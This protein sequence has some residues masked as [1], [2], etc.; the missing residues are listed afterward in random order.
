M[1]DLVTVT[2]YGHS[3]TP[4]LHRCPQESFVERI[5]SRKGPSGNLT[6]IAGR[7]TVW[8][9]LEDI[10]TDQCTQRWKNAAEVNEEIW[11]AWVKKGKRR[12]AVIAGGARIL[13]AIVLALLAFGT[14]QSISLR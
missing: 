3:P 9:Q 14:A 13:T 10:R 6:V 2:I 11:R 12:D 5:G 1:R 7:R 4:E 8:G